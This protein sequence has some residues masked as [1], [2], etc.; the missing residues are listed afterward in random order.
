MYG[1]SDW[2]GQGVS[3]EE[4]VKR[5]GLKERQMRMRR[6][7]LPW[8]GH[9]S[10]KTDGVVLRIVEGMEIHGR[11]STGRQRRTWKGSVIGYGGFRIRG[12][13]RTGTSKVEEDH[14]KSDMK[15]RK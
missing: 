1:W 13:T 4:V 8:F 6:R 2:A 5:C 9:V 14:R 7:R 3:G 12:R 15:Y 10:K 11:R